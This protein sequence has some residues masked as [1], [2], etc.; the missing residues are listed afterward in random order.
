ML[1]SLCMLVKQCYLSGVCKQT[2]LLFDLPVIF[3]RKQVGYMGPKATL[4][5]ENVPLTMAERL[6]QDGF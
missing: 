6:E 1:S 3:L 4:S 2:F 5:S